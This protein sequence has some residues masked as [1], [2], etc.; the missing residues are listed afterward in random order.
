MISICMG[1]YQ[2]AAYIE[3]Q[4]ISIKEQTHPADEVILCDDCSRD[5]TV[6]VIQ[7][8]LAKQ[9]PS[10]D[11]KLIRNKQ[12]K[13]YPGNFYYAMSLCTGDYVFLAD[14]DDIWDVRKLEHMVS[15]FEKEPWVKA[16]CCKFSLID[17]DGQDLHTVMAPVRSTESRELRKVSAAD[18]F[19]KCEWP[20]M[21]V[22]YRREWF[23]R[24]LQKWQ[25]EQSAQS[26]S[27]QCR[28]CQTQ[29]NADGAFP[30]EIPHDFLV[31]AWAA[32]EDGFVQLD[33][34]LAYH[35]RHGNNA[36]GEEHRL[37]KLLNKERKLK[38]IAVYNHI[39]ETFIKQQVMQLST[40]QCAL[41]EKYRVM[42]QR[43]EALQSGSICRVAVNAWKNRKYTRI[44]TAI[45][46]LV[47]AL[48]R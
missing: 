18:V 48:R 13:G 25:Q 17:S 38:E 26:G 22:A 42:R 8:F 44:V 36:G 39:L 45:C 4:L 27:R 2:G 37:A 1:T 16:V 40:G 15:V 5:N 43:L 31:C 14:Q 9:K 23:H 11:W 35:R 47:I 19:Y 32:E 46:D 28:E 29:Q 24:K 33:E 41:E 7:D 30:A 3:Q 12:N 6:E 21:V 34:E 20:G 10:G